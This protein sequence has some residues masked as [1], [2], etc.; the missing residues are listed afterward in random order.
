[1]SPLSKVIPMLNKLMFDNDLK[2]GVEAR[3]NRSQDEQQAR[4]LMAGA[5]LNLAKELVTAKGRV[6][7]WDGVL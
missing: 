7:S 2:F 1:M 5:T 3:K 4:N 6:F